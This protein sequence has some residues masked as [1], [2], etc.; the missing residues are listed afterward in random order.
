M[1]KKNG[2]ISPE[3]K[4]ILRRLMETPGIEK[5]WDFFKGMSTNVPPPEFFMRRNPKPQTVFG[6]IREW[7]TK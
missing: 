5:E 7:F 2:E 3:E 4:E 1:R 6:R